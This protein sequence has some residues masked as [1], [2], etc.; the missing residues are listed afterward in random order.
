[1]NKSLL[2]V[3]ALLAALTG[4]GFGAGQPESQGATKPAASVDA[5]RAAIAQVWVNYSKYAMEG[6]LDAFLDLHERNAYK[7]PQD[8]PMFQPWA[9]ADQMRA[10]W[11]KRVQSTRMEMSIQPID[12]E[13]QGDYAYSM[14]TYTQKFTPKAGG[15]TT[16][17]NGKYLDVL[18]KDS[19]GK[20]RILRD[21]YNSN[22]PPAN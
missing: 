3:L 17:F 21:C 5:D 18:H 10:S 7:M 22:S 19:D 16:V 9:I 13:V 1:M 2:M 6:N 8:Q 4:M 11:V 12:I 14:G 15:E 20:W